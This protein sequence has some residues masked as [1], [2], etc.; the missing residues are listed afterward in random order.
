MF[1]TDPKWDQK[2]V[3][4]VVKPVLEIFG[5]DRYV[6]T[7]VCGI[8]HDIGQ[9]LYTFLNYSYAGVYLQATFLWTG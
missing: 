4:S 3:E 6:R 9:Q 5:I 8:I 2:S 7:Y 1:A